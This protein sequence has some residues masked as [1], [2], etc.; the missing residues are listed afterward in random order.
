MGQDV[1]V[2]GWGAGV[3]QSPKEVRGGLHCSASLVASAGSDQVFFDLVC[4]SLGPSLLL[5][6]AG[7]QES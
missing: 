7:G 4:V 5:C 2:G 6:R 3:Q 1:G